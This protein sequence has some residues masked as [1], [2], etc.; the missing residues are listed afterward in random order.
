MLVEKERK[1]QTET[2]KENR[3]LEQRSK[4]ERT[5]KEK[6]ENRREAK[7]GRYGWSVNH[8]MSEGVSSKRR[9]GK[10]EREKGTCLGRDP[11]DKLAPR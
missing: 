10:K 11:C 8:S 2:S 4:E 5:K 6:T 9:Q 3:W 7:R 1:Q